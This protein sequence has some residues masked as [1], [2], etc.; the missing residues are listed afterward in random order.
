MLHVDKLV[1]QKLIEV[2]CLR[3]P[4]RWKLIALIFNINFEQGNKYRYM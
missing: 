3:L 2:T 1:V 4:D